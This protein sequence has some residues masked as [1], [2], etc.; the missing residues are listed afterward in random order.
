MKPEVLTVFL[1]LWFCVLFF[2]FVEAVWQA[3]VKKPLQKVAQRR[4]SRDLEVAQSQLRAR[5]LPAERGVSPCE[6]DSSGSALGKRKSR[7]IEFGTDPEKDSPGSYGALT[8]VQ[9]FEKHFGKIAEFNV[10]AVSLATAPLMVDQVCGNPSCTNPAHLE[11]IESQ[12][13]RKRWLLRIVEHQPALTCGHDI[14]LGRAELV[15][16]RA[17]IYL[18][19]GKRCTRGCTDRRP[20]TEGRPILGG[21]E[22][23]WYE[24]WADSTDAFEIPD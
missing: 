14:D 13:W 10:D 11:L 6:V 8:C 22:S 23:A 2:A 1:I 20:D 15:V 21:L 24:D 18:E 9:A 7:S 19:G 4:A 3:S 17:K 5:V 16:G 12:D